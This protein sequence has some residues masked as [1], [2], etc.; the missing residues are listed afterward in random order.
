[1]K[2]AFAEAVY[3][4]RRPVIPFFPFPLTRRP[5]AFRFLLATV[6]RAAPAAIGLVYPGRQVLAQHPA[7]SPGPDEFSEWDLFQF[8]YAFKAQT[9][10]PVALAVHY[11]DIIGFGVI[12]Y[13]QEGHKV[14]LDTLLVRDPIPAELDYFAAEM[15]QHGVGLSFVIDESVDPDDL[16]RLRR[17]ATSFVYLAGGASLPPAAAAEQP[18]S[19]PVFETEN[20]NHPEVSTRGGE[21]VVSGLILEQVLPG[22]S[23]S[24][25]WE[26]GHVSAVCAKVRQAQN[27]PAAWPRAGRGGECPRREGD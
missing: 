25:E 17:Y 19:A 12:P 13:G 9:G 14:G 5:E 22:R 10:Q 15:L 2:Q 20:G 7:L 3:E 8:I 4:G 21:P 16:P 27:W 26:E 11:R 24:P 23:G 18:E 1:M 6:D